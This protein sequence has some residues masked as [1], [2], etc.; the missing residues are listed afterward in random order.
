MFAALL[1]TLRPRRVRK[2]IF[3]LM[4]IIH[5]PWEDFSILLTVPYDFSIYT[6]C[7][8][9]NILFADFGIFHHEIFRNLIPHQHSQFHCSF[10]PLRAQMSAKRQQSPLHNVGLHY[11]QEACPSLSSSD[12]D[13]LQQVITDYINGVIDFGA[14]SDFFE[15]HIH[16]ATPID[17]LREV[18]IVDDDPLPPSPVTKEDGHRQKTR[19]WTNNEDVRLLAAVHRQGLDNWSAVASFVGS[20]RTRSQCSQRWIRGLD[21]RISRTQWTPEEDTALVRLVETYGEKAWIRVSQGLGTRS[22]VQCRYRYKQIQREHSSLSR[23]PPENQ[24]ITPSDDVS[25]SPQIM[26]FEISPMELPREFELPSIPDDQVQLSSFFSPEF[27]SS[28]LFPLTF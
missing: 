18:L 3:T 9:T 8:F 27:G 14:A 26:I 11:T 21:P 1:E 23:D 19:P 2:V 24:E 6:K 13:I 16:D 7:Q 5:E 25:K 22:D 15:T 17:R 28:T 4:G 10:R 12:R 20:S